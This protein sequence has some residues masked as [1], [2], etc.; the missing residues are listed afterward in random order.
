MQSFFSGISEAKDHV[1]AAV[2]LIIAS[3]LLIGRHQAGLNNLRKASVTVFSYL[4][5]PFSNIRIYQQAL[6]TNTYLRRQNVLLLDELSRLRSAEQRNKRLRKLLEFSRES[7]L[8]LYPVQVVGK[9]LN[10]AS[11]SFTIDAGANHGIEPGMPMVGAEG[12][13][14]KVVLVNEE[15]AKVMPLYN[16]LFRVSAKLQQSNAYGIVSWNNNSIRELELNYVPQ[17]VEVDTGEVVITSG[18]SNQFPPGIPIGKVSRT[19]PQKGKD[20]QKIFLKPFVNLYTIEA[21]FVIKF[22]ADTLIQNLNQ[23]YRERMQ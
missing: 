4:E 11:N 6:K 19:Q 22:E 18:Y 14:G 5:E 10:Q 13:A 17:T 16:V 3:L 1:I 9:K 21:G 20:T 23:R 2:L 8:N 12:L 7:N 15:Y